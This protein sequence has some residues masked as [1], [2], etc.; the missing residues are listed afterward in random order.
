[1]KKSL[2]CISCPLGCSLDVEFEGNKIISVDGSTCKRGQAYAEK[3]IFNPERIVTSTVKISGAKIEF[4][5]VKTDKTVS[6]DCMAEVMKEIF[7]IHLKAPIKVGDII[8]KN[9][10]GTQANLIATRSFDLK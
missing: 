3:E 5:P 2:I 9:I 8:C 10:A 4:L 1:M 7:K 6:K